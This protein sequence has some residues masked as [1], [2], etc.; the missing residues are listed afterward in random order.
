MTLPTLTRP[1]KAALVR[2]G[3]T[4]AQTAVA[5]IGAALTIEA[6]EWQYVASTSLLA[7]LLSLLKSWGWGTPET[8]LDKPI[9]D[10]I[11]LRSNDAPADQVNAAVDLLAAHVGPR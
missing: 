7:G 5:T 4:V 6:V 11:G 2:A 1:V 3:H 8:A 10:L 9:D